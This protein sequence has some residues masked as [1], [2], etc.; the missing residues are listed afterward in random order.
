MLKVF[1]FLSLVLNFLFGFYLLQ[2]PVSTQIYS[3]KKVIDGDTFVLTSQQQIRLHNINAP[4]LNLCGGPQAKSK[5][6]SLITDKTVRLVGDTTDI[7]GRR[8][9]LVYVGDI[10]INEQMLL[11][12]WG[13]FTSASSSENDRL[14][15]AG[16]TARDQKLGV[17]GSLCRQSVNPLK[18]KCSIKGNHGEREN[19]Y[20]FE[21]CGSYPNTVLELDEGDAWFCTEA[22]AQAAGFTKAAN[23]YQ[24]IFS[25]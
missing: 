2:P 9:A 6:E 13:K 11:S 3:V 18:P 10:L 1:L 22:E 17:Y 4:E 25:P 8:I 5:L 16:E 14:K 15:S 7:F 12:G 19:I 20:S 24:K 23:C 21:G